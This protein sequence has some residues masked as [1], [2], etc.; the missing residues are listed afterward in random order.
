MS[1]CALHEAIINTN[2]TGPLFLSWL[3]NESN[4]EIER[5]ETQR[6]KGE[7]IYVFLLIIFC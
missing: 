2:R 7:R 6:K 1:V 5:R 3:K 4:E